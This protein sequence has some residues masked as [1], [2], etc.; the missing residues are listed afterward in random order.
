MAI[1]YEKI[2][3][4]IKKDYPETLE[5]DVHCPKKG[6]VKV[7]CTLPIEYLEEILKPWEQERMRFYY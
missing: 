5:I 3:D 6:I 4:R 2:F 1:T 7:S